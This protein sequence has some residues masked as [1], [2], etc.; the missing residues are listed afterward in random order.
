MDIGPHALLGD[1][2]LVWGSVTDRKSYSP[3]LVSLRRRERSDPF[4]GWLGRTTLSAMVR[5]GCVRWKK[6]SRT[7]GIVCI[8]E[9]GIIVRVTLWIT[10]VFASLIP[11]ASV[12]MLYIVHSVPAR[13]G[14]IGIFNFIVS[15]AL[16][17]FTGAKRSEIFAVS[18]A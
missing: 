18:A 9:D 15:V 6:P 16:S 4:S 11:V 14:M 10:T 5:Y 13:L 12:V 17:I 1:D 7:H 8:H 2:S 3:D